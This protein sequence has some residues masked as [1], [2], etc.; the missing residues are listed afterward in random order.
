MEGLPADEFALELVLIGEQAAGEYRRAVAKLWESAADAVGL[1]RREPWVMLGPDTRFTG[2]RAE[3]LAERSMIAEVA[4]A[5]AL[6]EGTIRDWV[7]TVGVLRTRLAVL[8]SQFRQGLV[9]ERNVAEA[10][11]IAGE[12]PEECWQ[13]FD[14]NVAA[15]GKLTPAKFR[16]AARGI[17][18]RL[19][20][21]TA[22]V[23][24]ARAKADRRVWIEADRDG[25]GYLGA[26][27]PVDDLAVIGAR[28][29]Q[30]AFAQANDPGESRT[31]AQ[32][33]ADELVQALAGDGVQVKVE[34]GITVPMLSLTGQPAPSTL[35]GLGPVP[36]VMAAKLA[37]AAT[38]FVRVLTD[39][40]DGTVLDLEAK[41]RRVTTAMR[42]FLRTREQHCTRPA[43]ARRAH[44]S[45]IDHTIDVQHGGRTT[46]SNLATLCRPDHTL[47]HTTRWR[48]RQPPDGSPPGTP[49]TWTS[50]LGRTYPADPPF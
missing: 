6:P 24:H 32:L 1:A 10:V 29:D 31:V 7:Y 13:E 42:R 19:Q 50:P 46:V 9:S 27:L 5:Q 14:E 20:A 18:E 43:C 16:L 45:D 2:A 8:W 35:H 11:R 4:A 21:S 40:I 26:Y 47:K 41:S 44:H 39:P 34:L 28:L 23:R 30:V 12:L 38:S 49:T 3:T 15:V 33:R 36:P 25:M 48:Y 17:R 22:D 37:G